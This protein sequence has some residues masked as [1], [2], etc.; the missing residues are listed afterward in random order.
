MNEYSDYITT[1]LQ[2]LLSLDT[3][4]YQFV[5]T[6]LVVLLLATFL[7]ARGSLSILPLLF[8]YL[9]CAL[10]VDTAHTYVHRQDLAY[11]H[12]MS[13]L[14]MLILACMN[15]VACVVALQWTKRRFH[16]LVFWLSVPVVVYLVFIAVMVGTGM[17]MMQMP[18][19]WYQPNN[20]FY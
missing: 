13:L 10:L 5:S 7:L 20:D 15:I 14:G 12:D 1:L 8:V 16:P 2:P 17:V 11:G 19:D 3:D 9:L 6:A 4:I 18:K